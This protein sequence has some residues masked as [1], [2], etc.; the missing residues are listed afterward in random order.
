MRSRRRLTKKEK[1]NNKPG[2]LNFRRL[3][4]LT[5]FL[6]III[7]LTIF[8]LVFIDV[9][10]SRLVPDH[11]NTSS[12]TKRI[13]TQSKAKSLK[14]RKPKVAIIVDD[15]GS[16]K[17]PIDKLM[18]IK[19][20]VNFAILPYR[21]YSKYA[22]EMANKKGWDVILHLPM[23]PK[24]SSGYMGSDAGEGVLLV[25]STKEQILEKLDENLQSI[26]YIKGVNNHMGSKFT[27]N[28]E[29]MEVVLKRLSS[30]GLFYVDSL[31]TQNSKGYGIARTLG[32][33]TVKRDIFLDE[34]SE[35]VQYV[36][37]QILKLITLSKQ[38]G[39]AV[40]ICHPYPQT[41]EALLK[42]LQNLY[43]EVEIA[44]ISSVIN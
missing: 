10:I 7:L 35:G 26:P 29:L 1:K 13:L 14:D 40:G 8:G 30:K 2:T 4:T 31:T 39:Y 23:E 17:G 44:S 25:G 32:M 5:S 20:P 15:L 18:E 9:R 21:P 28:G 33:K 12:E 42:P 27:E 16:K 6:L 24:D 36:H 41:V 37:S 38:R 11:R 3:L 34:E 43:K 19:F 22:A